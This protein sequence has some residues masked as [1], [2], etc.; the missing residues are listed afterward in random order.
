MTFLDSSVASAIAARVATVSVASS[1]AAIRGAT[2]APPDKLAVLPYAV[3]LPSSDRVEHYASARKIVCYFTVRLYLGS[4]QDFARRFPALHTY[5][6][7]LR[8]IFVGDVTLGGLVDL[9]S[10]ESTR[11]G[12]DSYAGDDYVTVEATV[13]CVKGESLDYHA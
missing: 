2:A 7:A 13:T 10:V 3:V 8:D 1:V 12:A 4:P 11:I 9:A 5:R 6:T